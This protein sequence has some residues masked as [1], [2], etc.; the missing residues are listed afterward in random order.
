MHCMKCGREIQEQQVFCPDCL[1]HMAQNLV[2]PGTVVKLPHRSTAV[3]SKKRSAGRKRDL[4]PEEL[5]LHQRKLIRRL[6][7]ALFVA[8]LL[9]IASGLLLI[10]MFKLKNI[11]DIPDLAVYTTAFQ[12]CFT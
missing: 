5:V 8:A 7:F 6:I 9:L 2:K 12:A 1:A 3:L 10:W 11:V 4:K